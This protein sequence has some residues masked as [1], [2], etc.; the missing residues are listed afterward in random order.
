ML[1]CCLV[2]RNSYLVPVMLCALWSQ[3]VVQQREPQPPASVLENTQAMNEEQFRCPSAQKQ[4]TVVCDGEA[5]WGNYFESAERRDKTR[6]RRRR[7]R[8]RRD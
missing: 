4:T 1:C 6:R 8:R 5:D 7:R 2:V 3:A